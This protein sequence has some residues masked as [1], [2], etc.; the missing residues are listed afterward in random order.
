MLGA[1]RRRERIW[2]REMVSWWYRTVAPNTTLA[3]GGVWRAGLG[4]WGPLNQV[5]LPEESRVVSLENE[6]DLA[7]WKRMGW[8]EGLSRERAWKRNNRVC[9]GPGKHVGAGWHISPGEE[10]RAR[11]QLSQEVQRALCGKAEVVEIFVY[12][13]LW[14]QTA[15]WKVV[16]GGRCAAGERKHRAERDERWEE[17]AGRQALH[18]FRHW[19]C[20]NEGDGWAWLASNILTLEWGVLVAVQAESLAVLAEGRG[21]WGLPSA[22]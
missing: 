22:L 19:D 18:L 5:K 1:E 11:F 8:R 17:W 7:R 3:G 2:D 13:E 4:G 6:L 15:Q 14:F 16:S 20:R 21:R 10:R 9:V 12:Q